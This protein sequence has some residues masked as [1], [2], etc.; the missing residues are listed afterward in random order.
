ME[1]AD[2]VLGHVDIL[3]RLLGLRRGTTGLAL[4]GIGWRRLGSRR[5]GGWTLW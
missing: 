2:G 4:Q 5:R 3:G 1:Q